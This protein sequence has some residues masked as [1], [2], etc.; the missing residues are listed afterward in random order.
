MNIMQVS[1]KYPAIVM[2]TSFNKDLVG[3]NIYHIQN[4]EPGNF[5]DLLEEIF[6]KGENIN[7]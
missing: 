5:M 3:K 1:T 2:D 6:H 4:F 7:D